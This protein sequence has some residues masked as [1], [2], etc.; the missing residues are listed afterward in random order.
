MTDNQ[1]QALLK[2]LA[3]WHEKLGI[4]CFIVGFFQLEHIIGG[5][6]GGIV[7]FLVTL[8]IRMWSAQ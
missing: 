8:T 5:I 1:R 3:D 7:C 4:G 6:I 2:T